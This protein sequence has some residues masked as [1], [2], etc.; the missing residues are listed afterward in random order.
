MTN[1]AI[2]WNRRSNSNIF[3]SGVWERILTYIK[4]DLF[5][6]AILFSEVNQISQTHTILVGCVALEN[7]SKKS[8]YFLATH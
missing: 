7:P 5:C 8:D 1:S 4:A 6:L 3:D 2:V